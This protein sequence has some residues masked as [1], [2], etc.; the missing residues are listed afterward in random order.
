MTTDPLL[1]RVAAATSFDVDVLAEQIAAALEAIYGPEDP[2]DSDLRVR[3]VRA[4]AEHISATHVLVSRAEPEAPR[5]VEQWTEYGVEYDD[6]GRPSYAGCGRSVAT[7]DRSIGNYGGK[8][9]ERTA[10][11]GPWRPPDLIDP[12]HDAT[13]EDQ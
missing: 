6:R 3:S 13:L 4:V 9:V 12:T 5:G 2:E 1:T 10:T 7:R 8:P 11:A